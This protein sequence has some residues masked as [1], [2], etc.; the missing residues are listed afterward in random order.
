[1]ICDTKGDIATLKNLQVDVNH[2]GYYGTWYI[3]HASLSDT[4]KNII[5]SYGGDRLGVNDF[6]KIIKM[7]EMLI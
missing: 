4:T 2:G 7:V 1:M 6:E 3:L 5:K